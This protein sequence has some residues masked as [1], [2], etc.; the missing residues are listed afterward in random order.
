[1][2]MTATVTITALDERFLERISRRT[3]VSA[4]SAALPSGST[5]CSSHAGHTPLRAA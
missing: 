3:S 2:T 5:I 1:M 4:P